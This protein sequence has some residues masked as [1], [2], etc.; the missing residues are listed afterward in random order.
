MWPKVPFPVACPNYYAFRAKNNILSSQGVS[1]SPIS[2][3]KII[4]G[5]KFFLNTETAKI[6]QNMTEGSF[7]AACPVWENSLV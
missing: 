1:K 7:P 4:D 3:G 6:S 5:C 2:Y